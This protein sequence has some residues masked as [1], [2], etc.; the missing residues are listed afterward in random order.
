M[1]QHLHEQLKSVILA[2]VLDD[3]DRHELH[4]DLRRALDGDPEELRRVLHEW[5]V[6]VDAL[7][8]PVSREILLAR[9]L[10]DEEFEEVRRP[11]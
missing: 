9:E 10:G 8:D 11:A 7:K 5:R 4:S 1:T 2:P 3:E 6:T